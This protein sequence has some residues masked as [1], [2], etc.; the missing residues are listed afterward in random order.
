[1]FLDGL[2]LGRHRDLGLGRQAEAA[3]REDLRVGIADGL[4]DGLRH[5]R[6]AIDL[7]EVAHRHLA[8]TKAVEAYLV[9]EVDQRE[10]PPWHRDP[11]R[12]R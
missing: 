5:H 7:L 12:E 11:M 6:A 1:M 8:G 4:I 2:L 9:L 3:L 10:R